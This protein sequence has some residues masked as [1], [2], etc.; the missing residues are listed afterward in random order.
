MEAVMFDQDQ[1][2]ARFATV[3]L[4]RTPLTWSHNILQDVIV[5]LVI[6]ANF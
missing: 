2:R 3:Y 5:K 4:H 6:T 1:V